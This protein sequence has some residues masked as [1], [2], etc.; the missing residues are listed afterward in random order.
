MI[1]ELVMINGLLGGI[2]MLLYLILS[3]LNSLSEKLDTR[4]KKD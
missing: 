1:G 2:T 3:R 4:E